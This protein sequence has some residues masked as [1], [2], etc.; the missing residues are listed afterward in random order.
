M[1]EANYIVS[2]QNVAEVLP[3]HPPVQPD[4]WEQPYPPVPV[5]LPTGEMVW[6]AGAGQ[7]VYCRAM[8]WVAANPWMATAIL[9]AGWWALNKDGR[10]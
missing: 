8:A 3:L 5:N 9:V 2:D 4:D 6:N 1:P 7:T 10:R